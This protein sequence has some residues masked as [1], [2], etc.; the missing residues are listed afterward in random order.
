MKLQKELVHRILEED[1]F[2]LIVLDACRYDVFTWFNEID[3]TMKRVKSAGTHTYVWLHRVFTR[4]YPDVTVYSQHPAIN[5]YGFTPDR[6]IPAVNRHTF[7]ASVAN[8]WIAT[9]HFNKDKIIDLW[10]GDLRKKW[11]NEIYGGDP[12]TFFDNVLESGLDKKNILWCMATHHPYVGEG[13]TKQEK[14]VSG[15]KITLRKVRNFLQQTDRDNVIITADHG[16]I[17]EPSSHFG[18]NL[19]RDLLKHEPG[20]PDWRLLSVPWFNV[21]S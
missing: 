17:L 1:K 21:H 10:S 6:W 5:S 19:H 14:Y 8:K 20:V 11:G 13:E 16:E 7:D 3:G 18:I 12:Q 2:T 9:E 4:H 15:V